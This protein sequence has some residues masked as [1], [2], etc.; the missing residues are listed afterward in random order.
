MPSAETASGRSPLRLMYQ[1]KSVG[2]I[3]KIFRKNLLT[4]KVF[5]YTICTSSTSTDNKE[6]SGIDYYDIN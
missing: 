2:K 5:Y 1:G 4:R 6:R 3:D